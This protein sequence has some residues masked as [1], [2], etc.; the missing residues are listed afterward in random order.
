MNNEDKKIEREEIKNT[1]RK[2]R[3]IINLC[4]L[5]QYN[6]M[7]WVKKIITLISKYQLDNEKYKKEIIKNKTEQL[8]T[9]RRLTII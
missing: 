7:M 2:K 6:P 1:I 4:V 5:W 9:D 8:R 3:K